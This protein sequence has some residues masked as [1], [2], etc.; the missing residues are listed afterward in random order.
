MSFSPWKAHYTFDDILGDSRT[1]RERSVWRSALRLRTIQQFRPES[2]ALER[3]CLH[4]RFTTA[5][6]DARRPSSRRSRLPAG[7]PGIIQLHRSFERE[8]VT[9]RPE[10]AGCDP[11]N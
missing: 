10:R 8:L 3:S 9:I 11:A 7:V 5:A 1:L 6:R 2:R 4:M